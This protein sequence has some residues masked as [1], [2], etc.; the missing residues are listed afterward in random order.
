V[1]SPVFVAIVAGGVMVALRLLILESRTSAQ[2]RSSSVPRYFAWLD[3]RPQLSRSRAIAQT[4]LAVGLGIVLVLI[5][6]RS[7][8]FDQAVRDAATPG[9]VLVAVVILQFAVALAVIVI[10]RAKARVSPRTEGHRP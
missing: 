5:L 1:T 8:L 3:T 6:D 2:Q 9:L 10:G 7:G 4:L